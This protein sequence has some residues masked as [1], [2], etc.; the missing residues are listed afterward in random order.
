[1]SIVAQGM[2]ARGHSPCCV[3]DSAGDEKPYL[4]SRAVRWPSRW[5]ADRPRSGRMRPLLFG[6]VTRQS[7]LLFGIVTRQSHLLVGIVTRQSHLL[8]GIAFGQLH[9]GM[10]ESVK[11]V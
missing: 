5:H 8:V 1:M 3:L 10:I 6:I 4:Y 2:P 11:I 7:H 9:F